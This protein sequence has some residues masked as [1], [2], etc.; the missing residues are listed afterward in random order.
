MCGCARATHSGY[1]DWTDWCLAANLGENDVLDGH[2]MPGLQPTGVSRGVRGSSLP[3][4]VNDIAA[5]KSAAKGGKKEIAA[6]VIKPAHGEEAP[7]G[8]LKA[9]AKYSKEVGALLVFDEITSGFRMN[10]GGIPIRYGVNPDIAVFAKSVANG[11]AMAAFIG[12]DKVMQAAQDTFILSTNWTERV[13][14]TAD[15]TIIKKYRAKNVHEHIIAIGEEVKAIW[16]AAATSAGPEARVSGLFTLGA[17][18]FKGEH[19]L[20]M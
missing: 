9:L 4:A 1:H 13:G 11:Y 10:A 8:Y 20:A 15:L 5:L 6:I 14:L 3:V 2:L 19:N 17:F 18:A 12:R 7:P 16:R